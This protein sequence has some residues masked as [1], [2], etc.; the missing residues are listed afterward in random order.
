MKF[1]PNDPPEPP[2]YRKRKFYAEDVAEWTILHHRGWSYRQLSTEWG[3][4]ITTICQAVNGTYPVP[5][6]SR[7]SEPAYLAL[8]PVRK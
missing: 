4:S 5:I 8:K 7:A 1:D 2:P 3:V 6:P